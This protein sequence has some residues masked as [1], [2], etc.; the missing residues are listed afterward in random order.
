M[1]KALVSR[2][3]LCV[4]TLLSTCGDYCT[5]FLLVGDPLRSPR[6]LNKTPQEVDKSI[7]FVFIGR[8]LQV[9]LRHR[10]QKQKVSITRH[11]LASFL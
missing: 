10:Q 8:C 4:Y 1:Q 7:D 3:L 5:R 9:N 11:L 2:R 6:G